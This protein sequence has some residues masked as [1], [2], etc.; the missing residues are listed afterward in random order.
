MSNKEQIYDQQLRI[1]TSGRDDSKA[2]NFNFP[3]EPTDYEVLERVAASGYF[4]KKSRLIDY[5]CGKGRVSFYLAYQTGCKSIGV[6]YDERLYNRALDNLEKYPKPY[7]VTFELIN[8]VDYIV[9]AESNRFF[10]FNPFSE[11]ILKSVLKNIKDSYYIN[12]REMYLFF[13][14]P[15][16]E[17]VATLATDIE[18]S[19]EDEI[20]CSDLFNIEDTRE[21]VLVF[22]VGE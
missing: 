13:Y 16:D 10:F 21:R 20:D 18:L 11:E 5:G 3:Y 8:A 14:Y 6:E 1:K 7:N 19:F 4:D 9:P 22:S 15:S 2:N 12:P 17:Y